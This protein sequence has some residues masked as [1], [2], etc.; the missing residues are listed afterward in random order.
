MARFTVFGEI[1]AH[2][3]ALA[4]NC[5]FDGLVTVARRQEG[6]MRFCYVPPG[7]RTPR[8]YNCQPDLVDKATADLVQKEHLSAPER[9]VLQQSERSRVEPE[10]EGTLYGT[11]TYS[12]LTQT[13][14]DE[15]RRGADDESEIGVFHDLFEP[16]WDANLRARLDEHTPAGLDV[17]IIYAS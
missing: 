15:I 1:Q 5:I 13:T 11:P 2:A 7:S 14:A 17:G 6:C 4:E 8:R 9:D 16:Q 3:I 12:R 10:F